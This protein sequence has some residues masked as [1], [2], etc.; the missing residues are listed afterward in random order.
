MAKSKQAAS[1]AK[2]ARSARNRA[3]AGQKAAPLK[4]ARKLARSAKREPQKSTGGTKQA[5]VIALLERDNGATV[6]ELIGVTGWLP[7]TTRADLTGLR[8]KGFLLNKG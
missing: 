1:S 8:H 5:R 4:P 2:P 3:A 6:A 7:H